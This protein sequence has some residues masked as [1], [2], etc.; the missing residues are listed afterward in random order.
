MDEGRKYY[1]DA[2]IKVVANG[3]VVTIGCQTV[4]A[5]TPKKLLALISDYLDDP[6]KAEA[7]MRENT[8]SYAS[9]F[10]GIAVNPV[11]R[12]ETATQVRRET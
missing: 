4:V 3:F 6:G 8:H 9:H 7:E 12:F 2:N 11:D 1:R 10:G 5:E